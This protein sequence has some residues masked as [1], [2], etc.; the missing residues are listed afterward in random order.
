[1]AFKTLSRYL[2]HCRM[3]TNLFRRDLC[4]PRLFFFPCGREYVFRPYL[5]RLRL[6]FFVVGKQ[7]LRIIGLICNYFTFKLDYGIFDCV[8]GGARKFI[9]AVVI[10]AFCKSFE[11]GISLFQSFKLFRR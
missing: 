2:W 11:I 1:M 9:R 5:L 10:E 3:L 7:S 8:V 4:K 6:A